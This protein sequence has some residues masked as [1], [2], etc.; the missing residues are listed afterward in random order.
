MADPLVSILIPCRNAAPWIDATLRSA[1]AQTWPHIEIILVD[2]GSTDDSLAIAQRH[3][4]PRVQILAQANAGAGAAR[5][6]A[7]DAA[8][9][10]YLQYLDADDLLDIDKIASQLTRLR[11]TGPNAVATA[12]WGRFDG[13]PVST[14]F[15][16]AINWRDCAPVDY[17]V[18]TF[19]SG[20]MMHPAAWLTPRSVASAAGPWK[21][22]LNLDDDGEYFTRIVLAAEQV[23]F[24]A[25]AVSYYRSHL[26]GSLSGARHTAAWRS[27][28]RVCALST[29]A[30]LSKENSPRSRQACALYWLRF[31]FA[32]YPEGGSLVDEALTHA[33]SLDPS[34]RRPPAGPTFEV[35]AGLLGWKWAKRL[36]T[37]L[38]SLRSEA[39]LKSTS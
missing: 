18:D 30:L 1:L 5:Q 17:L 20:G 13:D 26:P 2:D 37:S 38:R 14:V 21:N 6:R 35:A 32:A 28:F 15:S 9:G 10:E 16:P 7:L 22:D 33:H 11:A 34:V 19:M 8:Q 24:C 27:S 36:R 39:A 23:L 25:D 31:A 4:S 12:R 3:A 29:N